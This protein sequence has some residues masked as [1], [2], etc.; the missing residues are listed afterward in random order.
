MI[1]RFFESGIEVKRYTESVDE[2]GNPTKTWADHLTISGRIDAIS[3]DEQIVAGA[4]SVVA[5][6]MLFCRPVDISEKDR[7]VY[8]G[9]EYE[10]KF[11]D[12]PMNYGRFLQISLEVIR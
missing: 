3:G 10:V 11:V 5:T 6:H 1:E 12:N 9:Q 4:P 2:L 7:I 8:K